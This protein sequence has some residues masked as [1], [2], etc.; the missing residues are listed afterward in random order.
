MTDIPTLMQFLFEGN[1]LGFLQAIYVSAFQS[2][3]L[4]YGVISMIFAVGLYIR[5]NSLILISLIWILLGSLFLTAMP[6]VS[7][8]AVFL[9]IFGIAK[10]FV[11]LHT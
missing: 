6:I 11:V 10:L 4:F 2:A 9:M 5:T 7:N 8:L 3:D 1:Y